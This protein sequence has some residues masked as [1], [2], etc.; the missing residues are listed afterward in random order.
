MTKLKVVKRD[1][2][3]VDFSIDKISNAIAKAFT[4]LEITVDES[5]ITL[6]ALRVTADFNKKVKNI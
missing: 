3:I 5:V 6:I 1:G 2:K 4:A